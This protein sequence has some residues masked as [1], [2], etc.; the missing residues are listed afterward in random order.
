MV[1]FDAAA[2][3]AGSRFAVL[4]N[5]GV[6]LELAL[7]QWCLAKLSKDFGFTVVAPPDVAHH[8]VVEACG[9]R[10]RGS[11]D[12][13]SQIY[14]LAGTDLCLIGTSEIPLM[15]LHASQILQK[16]VRS[17]AVRYK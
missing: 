9:F 7:I 17:D 8:A 2:A 15:A 4:K 5:D 10:P 11:D 12:E 1:D 14:G 3:I 13:A 6:L 16:D